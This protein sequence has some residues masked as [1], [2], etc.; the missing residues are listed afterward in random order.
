MEK[1]TPVANAISFASLS[2]TPNP[3]TA[4]VSSKPS[5]LQHGSHYSLCAGSSLINY[6]QTF[7]QTPPR[8][9]RYKL[10]GRCRYTAYFQYYCLQRVSLYCRRVGILF[11]GVIRFVAHSNG[12]NQYRSWIISEGCDNIGPIRTSSE[13]EIAF[14]RKCLRLGQA[15]DELRSFG[16]GNHHLSG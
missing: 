8:I 13:H 3:T 5:M 15:S 10:R 9:C 7:P 14:Y 6:P 11:M 1:G 12:C 4:D 16:F 2:Y